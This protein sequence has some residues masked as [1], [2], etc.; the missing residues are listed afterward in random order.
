MVGHLTQAKDLLGC[1]M[2][3][4]GGDIGQVRDLYFDK[5]R[6]IVRYV[7]IDTRHWLPGRQRPGRGASR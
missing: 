6:W 5:E 7:V 2:A 4:S 3:A 1:R